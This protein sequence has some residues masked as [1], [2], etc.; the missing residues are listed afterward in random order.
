MK[1]IKDSEEK[2][3]CHLCYSI[4]LLPYTPSFVKGTHDRKQPI[5]ELKNI[6]RIPNLMFKFLA[7][8]IWFAVSKSL[9]G[10]QILCKA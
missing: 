1:Q 4:Q 5:L 2:K 3:N 7:A 10:L 9:H 8:D 6:L